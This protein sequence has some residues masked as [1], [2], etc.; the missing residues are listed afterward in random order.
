LEYFANDRWKGFHATRAAIRKDRRWL[1]FV[2]KDPDTGW[3]KSAPSTTEAL[4]K[5][6]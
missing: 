2:Y 3:M 1:V 5:K 6:P 4:E